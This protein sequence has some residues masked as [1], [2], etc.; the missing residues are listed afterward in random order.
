LPFSDSPVNKIND[1]VAI[2]HASWSIWSQEARRSFA[3]HKQAAFQR[4]V[5]PINAYEA[6]DGLDL[7][8]LEQFSVKV[9][10]SAATEQKPLRHGNHGAALWLPRQQMRGLGPMAARTPSAIIGIRM[11]R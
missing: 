8:G 6:N 3:E 10:L 4:R 11:W 9:A 1:V 7:A 5:G 2:G